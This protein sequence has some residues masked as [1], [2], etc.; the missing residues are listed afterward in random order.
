MHRDAWA[1]A[2]HTGRYSMSVIIFPFA[3][4]KAVYPLVPAYFL[5]PKLAKEP[6]PQQLESITKE[7]LVP[8]VSVLHR[9]I[10]KALTTHEWDELELEKTLHI[11]CKCLYFSVKSHMPSALSPLLGSFCRD[12]I[13]ILDSLSF[14]WSVTPSDGYL[15]RSKAGKISLLLFGTLV[16]RHRKYS[17]KRTVKELHNGTRKEENYAPYVVTLTCTVMWAIEAAMEGKNKGL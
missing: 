15:I 9:L 11:I 4:A 3:M 13:R 17:D 12:M 8:L 14:D 16:S 6:V 1:I 7:T 10:D 5:Q 2:M